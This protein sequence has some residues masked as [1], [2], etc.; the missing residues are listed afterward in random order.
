MEIDENKEK[1]ILLNMYR[2]LL[3]KAKPVIKDETDA[4]LIRKA[5]KFAVYAHRDQRRKSGE[6]Y[7]YHPIAVA[8]ICVDEIGLGVTSIISALLHDVVEDTE[9]KLEDIER[10]FGKKVAKIIDGLTKISTTSNN[11]SFSV[12]AENFR[13]M[14]LTI[15]EDT[16]VVLIKIADRLHNMR[17]LDSMSRDKQLKIMAETEYIYAPLAHRLGLYNI[18]SELEDLALKYSDKEAYEEISKKLEETQASRTRFIRSFV[19][20]IERELKKQSFDFTIKARTKSIRSIYNKMK[21]Q[22]IPFEEIY[23]IFAIRIIFDSHKEEE[24]YNCWKIYSIVTNFYTPNVKRLRDWISVPK[25]NGYES[26][27]T[28]VMSP[29]GKWVEVQIRSQRM[30][31][32]AEKGYAAHWKYK[33]GAINKQNIEIGIENWLNKVREILEANDLDAIEFMN[34][35]RSNLFD[36][37][38]YVFTPK[39]ELKVLPAKATVLDFAFEIHSE[40]GAKCVGAKINGKL[41]PLNQEL[42]NGDQIEILTANK[43]KVNEGWLKFATTSKAKAKI[44][45]ELKEEKKKVGTLGKEIILRKIK[46]LK[47]E[48]N[49]AV[50]REMMEYFKVPSELELYYRVG[51]GIIEHNEIKRFKDSELENKNQLKVINQDD[52]SALKKEIKKKGYNGQD[53]LVIGD[54]TKETNGIVFH[55]ASCC[56]PIP[57]DDVFGFITINNGIKVHRTNCSNAVALMANYGYRI[58]KARWANGLSNKNQETKAFGVAL[59]LEGADRIGLIND[60]TKIIS[61]QMKVNMKS[62]NFN[63]QNSIFKG[64]IDLEVKDK[65]EVLTLINKLKEIDGII[66][67]TRYDVGRI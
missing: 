30:D 53:E 26:L 32:I 22:K 7:I 66:N 38:V 27:H 29:N 52:V 59:H 24:K 44:K 35:F 4:K 5:F 17:T 18:K 45:E 43:F 20:P 37:E 42:Q 15:A 13:R 12:Q 39:G 60:V 21:N 62:I 47:L 55:L 33:E 40:V 19:R 34:D 48:F 58:I 8:M 63:T 57:G 2:S 6:P 67:V 54:N 1:K 61:E 56:N 41:V 46:Q 23:D 28:T 10:E 16:R 31:D 9:Y 11:K 3:R 36:H 49:E 25:A 65:E 64:N 14:L 50:L 51:A